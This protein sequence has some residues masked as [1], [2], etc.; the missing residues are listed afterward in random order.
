LEGAGGKANL[1]EAATLRVQA[2]NE[3]MKRFD[4]T[5]AEI[6]SLTREGKPGWDV[7]VKRLLEH[8][9]AMQE[10][11]AGDESAMYV[12]YQNLKEATREIGTDPLML[13]KPYVVP[14]GEGL[15]PAALLV[16]ADFLIKRAGEIET[17]SKGGGPGD[18]ELRLMKTR[19]ELES[20]AAA[21]KTKEFSSAADGLIRLDAALRRID[22]E[23]MADVHMKTIEGDSFRPLVSAELIW[24]ALTGSLPDKPAPGMGLTRYHAAQLLESLKEAPMMPSHQRDNLM[25]S[26]VN[27]IV[28]PKGATGGGSYVR[29]EVINMA[30][31]WSE[32]SAGVRVDNRTGRFNVVHNG[33]WFESMDN[34]SRRW[35]E[36]NYGT[37]LTLPYT[38]N[39]MSTIKDVTTNK[40]TYHIALSGTTGKSFGG[41]LRD[42]RISVVGEG[43]SMP[44]NVLLEALATPE[45]RLVRVVESLKNQRATT[46]DQIRLDGVLFDAAPAAAKKGLEAHM[47]ENGMKLDDVFQISKVSSPEARLHLEG[48]RAN[49][50]KTTGLIVLS[51]SDTHALRAVE[52]RLRKE[53]LKQDEIAKVFADT[54]HLRRNVFEANVLRQMNIDGLTSG[55]VRVL[56]LDTRVGGRGLDLNFKG[57]RTSSAPTAFRGYTN[58]EMLVLGPEEMSG[59][60]MIQAMGRIDTGR[61]LGRA[62][63]KFSLLMDVEAAAKE[64]V[65]RRM[66]ETDPFFVEQRADPTFQDFARARGGKIDQVTF[67]EYI[68]VRAKEKPGEGPKLAQRYEKVMRK[69]LIDRNLEVEESLLTQAQ[70]RDA[71]ESRAEPKYP[72]LELIR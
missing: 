41:H 2:R 20:L 40:K 29:A 27:S 25:W 14:G 48:L 34:T 67:N 63:R 33:Q 19:Q 61:T 60:H 37:D 13:E 42:H 53:G 39:S 18:L 45:Q 55:K 59:V 71:R 30:K 12:K 26:Y 44:K 72:G 23:H 49:Q 38:H 46:L 57:D 43:S 62:T 1:S 6:V 16:R 31:G 10:A 7:Q 21:E 47:N 22:R 50:P 35:W 4:E 56:I 28:F 15:E 54:E 8:R 65:F 36:L 68:Q 51:V 52:R 64:S 69:H 5:G 66:F 58:F 70:V 24:Q 11:Y 32:S 17:K 9:R 3:I